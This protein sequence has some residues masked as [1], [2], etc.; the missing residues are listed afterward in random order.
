MGAKPVEKPWKKRSVKNIVVDASAKVH[1]SL[2][3]SERIR[4]QE[5][6]VK[7]KKAE[8]ELSLCNEKIEA[9]DG[10][11]YNFYLVTADAIR[12]TPT[13]KD[14]LHGPFYIDKNFTVKNKEL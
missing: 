13:G 2:A 1:A 7:Q 6:L 4:L 11:N 9:A 14:T 3:E 12:T 5:A 8:V 10:T